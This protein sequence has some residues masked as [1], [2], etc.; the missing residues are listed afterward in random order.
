MGRK[1][2]SLRP[3]CANYRYIVTLTRKIYNKN[4]SVSVGCYP[5]IHM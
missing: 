4:K 2:T 3:R 1:G 5:H